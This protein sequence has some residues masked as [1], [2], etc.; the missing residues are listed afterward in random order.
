MLDIIRQN[1]I[2]GTSHILYGPP[3]LP[4]PAKGSVVPLSAISLNLK[5]ET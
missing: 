5:I 2:N 3:T 4:L 1:E